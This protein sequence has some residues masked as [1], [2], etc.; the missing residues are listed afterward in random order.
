MSD[1]LKLDQINLGFDRLH[2]GQAV[3]QIVLI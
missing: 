1:H 2:E 3:R